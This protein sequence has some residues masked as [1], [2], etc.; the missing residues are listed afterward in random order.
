[1][2]AYFLPT[3][4]TVAIASSAVAEIV[5]KHPDVLHQ[6][7]DLIIVGTIRDLRVETEPKERGSDE[8]G[9][10]D[11]AIYLTMDVDR[12]EKGE[13]DQA[14]IKARC[15]RK[16]LRRSASGSMDAS[17]H[18]PIPEIGSKVRAYLDGPPSAWEVVLPNGIA[19][20]DPNSKL[21]D[22]E[23]VQQL[24]AFGFTYFLPIELWWPVVILVLTSFISFI[25]GVLFW[26]YWS[27]KRGVSHDGRI[28][29]SQAT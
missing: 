9:D 29:T 17:G 24:R 14:S 16:K 3:V 4:L 5:P 21:T 25:A 11:W 12:V 18:R 15:F 19:S 6:Y 7:A 20:L 13:F 27:R 26:K 8:T 23:Q 1:M 22:A 28:G 2:Q 10:S